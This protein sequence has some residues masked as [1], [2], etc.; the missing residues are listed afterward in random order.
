M[1]PDLVDGALAITRG[2]LGQGVGHSLVG[3]VALVP[4][5]V[6]R[7]HPYPQGWTEA[8]FRMP[9]P[10]YPDGY[11]FAPHFLVW[12]AVSAIGAWWLVAPTL[13]SRG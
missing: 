1:L 2:Q 6:P 3:L 7:W 8:W 9:V 10:G 12:C 5:G 11:P 4:L 13:R